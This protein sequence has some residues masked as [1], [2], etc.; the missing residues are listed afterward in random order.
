MVKRLFTL[1]AVHAYKHLSPSY[2]I[3]E[4]LVLVVHVGLYPAR[5]CCTS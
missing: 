2:A 1:C 5:R 3:Q 4:H